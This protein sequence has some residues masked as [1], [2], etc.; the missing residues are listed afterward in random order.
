MCRFFM[1]KDLEKVDNFNSYNWWKILA[2]QTK[3][4]ISDLATQYL[5]TPQYSLSPWSYTNSTSI[6][7]TSPQRQNSLKGNVTSHFPKDWINVFDNSTKLYSTLIAPD[8]WCWIKPHVYNIPICNFKVDRTDCHFASNVNSK[9]SLSS[10]TA[11]KTYYII[12]SPSR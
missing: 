7:Q 5:S 4:S 2:L 10:K 1:S 3:P 8:S 6:H 12:F 9:K 11:W